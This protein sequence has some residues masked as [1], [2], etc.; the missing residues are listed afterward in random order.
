[1]RAFITFF[2]SS[3]SLLAF[4]QT[5]TKNYVKVMTARQPITSSIP[6]SSYGNAPT[7][8]TTDITYYDGLGRPFQE[9]MKQ[10]TPN[11]KDLVKPYWYDA[12]GRSGKDGLYYEADQT[13][14]AYRS[15]QYT[16]LT[17]FYATP[18]SNEVKSVNYPYSQETYENSPLGRVLEHNAPG[19]T[20]RPSGF[21]GSHTVDYLYR[22]NAG[23]NIRLITV[24]NDNSQTLT[25][26]SN[27]PNDSL[28]V[29]STMDENGTEYEEFQ[30]KRGLL[31]CK[32][33]AVGTADETKTYYVYDTY[34]RLTFV[35]PPQAVIEIGTNWSL[36]ND[37]NFRKKWLFRYKYDDR[38]RMIEKQVPGAEKVEMVYDRRNRLV[39][40]LDGNHRSIGAL[41]SNVEYV[42]SG[43]KV[44]TSYEGKSYARAPGA[45]IVLKKPGFGA[46]KADGFSV[47][48]SASPYS[49]EWIFTKYDQRNRPVMTG[50]KSMTETRESLQAQIDDNTL[51][52]YAIEYVGNIGSDVFGYDNTSFPITAESEILTVTY[53]DDY[54]FV[55]DFTWGN[56]Y[57]HTGSQSSAHGLITGG[58]VRLLNSSNMLNSATYY[59]DRFRVIAVCSE[60]YFGDT[61][62]VVTSYIS[63]SSPLIKNIVTTHRKSG[64]TTTVTENFTYD[65]RDRLLT[66]THAI[67][68]NGTKTLSSN[69]YNEIGQLIE[70]DLHDD[71]T[72]AQSIDYRYNERG[73]LRTINGGSGTFDDASTDKFGLELK[74]IS[75]PTAQYNGNIGQ[76]L[77][78]SLGGS[79]VTTGGQNYQYAYD[80]LNRLKSATY[81]GSGNHNVSNISYD[82]NGNLKTLQRNTIDNLT[83]NH[84]GNQLTRA[85]DSGN[86]EGFK[87]II[88]VAGAKEYHYDDNG[89]MVSDLNK[90]IGDIN[91][92]FLNLPSTIQIEDV[93]GNAMTITYHYDALGIKHAKIVSGPS[94]QTSTYIGPFHY[95]NNDLKFIQHTE[96]RALRSGTTYNYEYDLTDHLGNVRVTV[97]EFGVV[98]Q[99]QDY[100]PFGGQFNQYTSGTENLYKLSGNEEQ[101]EWIVYDFDARFYDPWIGRF[102]ALDP[103]ADKR[104]WLTPYNYVQN[105]PL[106]RIDPTG[107]IDDYFDQDGNYLGTDKAETDNVRIISREQWDLLK[108][109]DSEGNETI[110][111]DAGSSIGVIHSISG[112][113]EEAS[114]NILNHYNTTD[115]PIEAR[116]TGALAGFTYG[117]RGGVPVEGTERMVAN[118]EKM[119]NQKISDH[120]NEL[121]STFVHEGQHY[122][123]YKSDPVRYTAIRQT[124]RGL[125][126]LERS[127]VAAQ[128]RH[129][130]FSG[131]RKGFQRATIN[132]GIRFGNRPLPPKIQSKRL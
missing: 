15:S 3:I 131:T 117:T 30:D 58:Q 94:S 5:S 2:L 37:N 35:I 91:Y 86:S 39:F 46:S 24:N 12:F 92:N 18:P 101:K 100:Y 126:A 59:D 114:V 14:G 42:A 84:D 106:L 32:K 13:N 113:S 49:S 77:W 64:A 69:R 65:H 95:Q 111:H 128:V 61:D 41:S 71:G 87:N 8:V 79:E 47:V 43:T 9:I 93:S 25:A 75:A 74:Y 52:D 53:Y 20:W 89:N 99:K 17:N 127:A 66:H 129:L 26:T 45:R 11:S 51:Y 103:L 123:D 80:D 120:A 55:S 6:L 10:A 102:K 107:T 76:M 40:V 82:D 50:I 54:D 28:W 119:K 63:T 27:H 73:W 115:L 22:P 122:L 125:N 68:S 124:D 83:F 57:Q 108:E 4:S 34:D 78:R 90:K 97:D 105:N 33:A 67:N 116:E 112:I 130:S 118:I 44:V 29:T 7:T 98:L 104:D 38:N 88:S 85:E 109:I 81:A 23:D 31:I 62:K 121:T 56:K 1:M 36:L 132:Y 110:D 60:N 72:P 48:K 19:D 16:E 70:K 21:G 96:G